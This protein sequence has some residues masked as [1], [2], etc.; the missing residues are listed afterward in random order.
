M[1]EIWRPIDGGFYEVSNY[2][3]VRSTDRCII[4]KNGAPMTLKGKILNPSPANNG[5]YLV[6]LE[7][8]KRYTIHRLVAKAF[9]PNPDNFPFINHKDENKLNNFVY[10]NA[11]GSIDPEQS[12]LEWCT[13]E[14]NNRYGTSPSR[15][16][17]TL[18]EHYKSFKPIKMLSLSGEVLKIFGNTLQAARFFGKNRSS[19]IRHVA[20]GLHGHKTAY[21]YKWEWA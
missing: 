14:Y 6:Y 12:N 13:V 7:N 4:R 19:V 15:V 21:G 18:R 2:G 1:E 8:R 16:S 10:V 17:A 3:R 9:I 11:D 5:Y 20:N